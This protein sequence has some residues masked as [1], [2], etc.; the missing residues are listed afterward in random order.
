MYSLRPVAFAIS[1]ENTDKNHHCCLSR[2]RKISQGTTI[3]P[4]VNAVH[5]TGTD[6]LTKG[7]FISLGQTLVSA[8][9]AFELGFFNPALSFFEA[10]ARGIR[11]ISSECLLQFVAKLV[12]VNFQDDL[13]FSTPLQ[14]CVN[15]NRLNLEVAT[16]DVLLIHHLRLARLLQEITSRGEPPAEVNPLMHLG[17]ASCGRW[18]HSDSCAHNYGSEWFDRSLC[19]MCMQV[20]RCQRI[21]GVIGRKVQDCRFCYTGIHAEGTDLLVKPFQVPPPVLL[22][23]PPSWVR[24]SQGNKKDKR[25]NDMMAK[26]SEGL[27]FGDDIEKELQFDL[28]LLKLQYMTSLFL[29]N[30]S[31]CREFNLVENPRFLKVHQID[32]KKAFLNGDLEEEIYMNQHEGFIAPGQEGKVPEPDLGI[33][34]NRDY[35]LH[36]DRH[37]AVIE[38]YSDANWISDIKDSRLTSGYVF[39]LGG[40]AISWKSSKQ[41]VI[42]KSTMESEF[43]AL[44]KCGEE[45]EWLSHCFFSPDNSA[46]QYLGIW[47]KNITIRKIIW[48]ANRESPLSISDTS[49]SLTIVDDGNLRILDGERNTVWSTNITLQ[50]NETTAKLT[51]TGDFCLNDTILGMILWESF[52]YPSNSLLPGMKLGMNGKT[53]GKHLMTS[54]KSDEDPTPGNFV[55]GLSADRPPQIFTWNGSKEYRSRILGS[56]DFRWLYLQPDGMFQMIYL[57]EDNKM[58]WE[59]PNDPCDVYGVCGAF[60]ICT[61][62]KSPTCDCLKGFVPESNEEWGKSNWTRGCVRRSE[63]LCEK[64]ESSLASGNGAKVTGQGVALG[65]KRG[66]APRSLSLISIQGSRWMQ[67]MVHG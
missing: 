2:R 40:A 50:S 55:V 51:D 46:K 1:P 15:A 53:Q 36:Y 58:A 52:D 32:V 33:C 10:D 12:C 37:P 23:V 60:A 4:M 59:E 30:R 49:S 44:D 6:I 5:C 13:N 57:D 35:G 11:A 31:L 63:L 3:E 43:I 67:R 61:S 45:A 20:P 22:K 47:F 24:N 42:A 19:I 38:G 62:N 65:Y 27:L 21:M 18:K 54:W 17:C 56:S 28:C 16:D 26:G 9:E 64:N 34:S 8:N 25:K 14:P 66:Q 29:Q 41:T 48:V 7:S 39:T